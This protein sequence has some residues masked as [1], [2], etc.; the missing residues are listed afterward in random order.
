MRKR[1]S[2][3]CL[4]REA[5][6]AAMMGVVVGEGAA[7]GGCVCVCGVQWR[8]EEEADDDGGSCVVVVVR[9]P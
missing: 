1:S 5:R 3:T 6:H 4:E 7:C 2:R 9:Q 8:E